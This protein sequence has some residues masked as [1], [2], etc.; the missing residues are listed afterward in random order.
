MMLSTSRYNTTCRPLLT[1]SYTPNT[2]LCQSNL[3]TS[4][5]SRAFATPKKPRQTKKS[6]KS[7]DQASTEAA[8]P[9]LEKTVPAQNLGAAATPF[10]PTEDNTVQ[11]SVA[12]EPTVVEEPVESE[13][14]KKESAK[15]QPVSKIFGKKLK[16][17]PTKAEFE[18]ELLDSDFNNF[19]KSLQGGED[20]PE[21]RRAE[22]LAARLAEHAKICYTPTQLEDVKKQM[23]KSGETKHTLFEVPSTIKN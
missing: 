21:G 22:Q 8:T 13:P 14:V 3:I 18:E 20:D 17:R 23:K 10:D 6:K 7:E 4:F 11:K 16:N 19:T 15:E 5:Q 2:T 9:A 1:A 12:K